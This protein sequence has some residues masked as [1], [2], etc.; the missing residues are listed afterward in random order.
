MVG[1][2]LWL[3]NADT[4]AQ[5]MQTFSRLQ[6]FETRY[7]PPNSEQWFHPVTMQSQKTQGCALLVFIFK[8]LLHVLSFLE[9]VEIPF[10]AW[11]TSE[12]PQMA[13]AKGKPSYKMLK[14]S[15]HEELVPSFFFQ[16]LEIFPRVEIIQCFPLTL[17]RFFILCLGTKGSL[18]YNLASQCYL[19]LFERSWQF[20]L[21][22]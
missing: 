8:Q 18:K 9:N 16:G 20:A 7:W 2:G 21:Q 10:Y 19:T 17:F 13:V 14:Y 1:C 5:C 6:V 4:L 22:T 15:T 12:N 3:L 11:F